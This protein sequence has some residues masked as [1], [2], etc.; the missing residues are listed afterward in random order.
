MTSLWKENMKIF[1]PFNTQKNKNG[2]S[3]ED[4]FQE[5][6]FPVWQCKKNEIHGVG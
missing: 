4:V 2:N 1:K 5:K 3:P 6:L